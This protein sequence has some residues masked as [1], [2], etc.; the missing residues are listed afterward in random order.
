[1]SLVLEQAP[2]GSLENL[3]QNKPIA[4]PRILLYRIAIQMASAL[5]FLHS[6]NIIFR[7]LKAGNI[8]LWSLSSD[9]LI[10]CKLTNFSIATHAEPEGT[11]GLHGT[12][13][14]IAPEVSHIGHTKEH[15]VYDHR[16]DIFSFSMFLY[17]LM[18]RQDPFYNLQSSSIEA[19]TEE[20]IRPQLEDVSVAE[21][22]LYY[23]THVII[24]GGKGGAM[25]L[26][27]H[28]I[29]SVLHRMFIFYHRNVFFSV[30]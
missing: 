9:Y 1:M 22:G 20:G 15:S 29:L 13:G 25:E 19:A 8:L 11:R 14:F 26:Q 2:L 24:G 4:L 10:N 27:P 12:K 16:A 7:D 3:L 21:V 23:M 5:C 28:L 17:Q 6:I 18:A 30:S